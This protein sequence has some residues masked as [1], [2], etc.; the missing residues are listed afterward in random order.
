LQYRIDARNLI[1]FFK[2]TIKYD[3]PHLRDVVIARLLKVADKAFDN[4]QMLDLSKEEL[5]NIMAKRPQVKASKVMN[6]LIKWS[7]KKLVLEA[8]K[9]EKKEESTGEKKAEDAKYDDV[10]MKEDKKE[11]EKKDDAKA[12]D[13]KKKRPQ[14]ANPMKKRRKLLKKIK[15]FTRKRKTIK[16]MP[17]LMINQK[18]LN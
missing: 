11:E 8:P 12:D 9:V 3:T 17:Q 14:K 4:E 15:R 13:T 6:V 18:L 10:E 5:L 16:R 7:K 1:H 2:N